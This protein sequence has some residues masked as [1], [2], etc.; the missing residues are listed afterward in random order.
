MR[1]YIPRSSFLAQALCLVAA[2]AVTGACKSGGSGDKAPAT[3]KEKKTGQQTGQ[4][5]GNTTAAGAT[6]DKAA[7]EQPGAAH[8]SSNRLRIVVSVDWEGAY[9]S[10]DGL[11]AL[12]AFRKK[13]PDVPIT[14]W[15][16]PAYFTKPEVAET[17]VADLQKTF[18]PGD[19]VALH[20]H[21][22]RSL[23]EAAG[24]EPK[25]APSFL[26]EEAELL[27]FEDGDVG[28]EVEIGAYS[29]ED[30]RAILRKSM[31]YLQPFKPRRYFRAGGALVAQHTFAA[32]AAEGF[33]IDSSVM[34][35]QDFRTDHGGTTQQ[36]KRLRETWGDLDEFALPYSIDTPGGAVLEVPTAPGFGD[37][38]AA[39]DLVAFINRA[40]KHLRANPEREVY[41]QLGFHQETA[42]ETS[43]SA[44]LTFSGRVSKA[45]EYIA[46][47]YSDIAVYETFD[48]IAK[49]H[50]KAGS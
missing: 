5:T 6:G 40:V 49:R 17:L 41:V 16:T 10:E 21:A 13:H 15:V 48:D 4:K 9:L 30:F 27:E 22:W 42:H 28:Y 33:T 38:H 19:I 37:Y 12:A 50:V 36:Q 46:T 14:H 11:A 20:V 32:L 29:A 44:P 8:K 3:D 2:L 31:E 7:G 39:V 34:R 25:L 26:S 18:L 24:V 47:H 43:D 1:Q 45:L 35:Y 23:A